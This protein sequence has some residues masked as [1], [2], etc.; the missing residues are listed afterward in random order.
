MKNVRLLFVLLLMVNCTTDSPNFAENSEF[1]PPEMLTCVD[2]LPKVRLT[3]NGTNNFDFTIY[4]LDYSQLHSQNVIATA[5]SSYVELSSNEVVLVVSN[6]VNYG[7]KVQLS[8]SNCDIVE[9]EV[10]ADN[11][12]VIN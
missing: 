3:N 1:S 2:D 12:L 11:L 10:D 7:Q 8:L 6:S 4:A 5:N 9:L